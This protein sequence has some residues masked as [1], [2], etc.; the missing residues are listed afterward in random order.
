[1]T[2][3]F[4]VLPPAHRLFVVFD[5]AEQG[6]AALNEVS[7]S[8]LSEPDDAWIF[9]GE[10]GVTSVDPGLRRHGV[11]V[12]IVRVLQRLMTSD[13]EYCEGLSR[14]LRAGP[15]VMALKVDEKA[16]EDVSE[17]LRR[18]GGH[19]MAYG[20]HWNFV[21]LPHETHTTTAFTDFVPG[22]TR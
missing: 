1:M 17:V 14:A 11:A 3:T 8:G 7:T 5:D 16:V 20:A 15:I 6:L 19:S 9:S 21:P 13:C 22:S 2:G 12:G 18:H 4:F 10:E